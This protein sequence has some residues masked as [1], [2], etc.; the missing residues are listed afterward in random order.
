MEL[1]ANI[2]IALLTLAVLSRIG[3]DNPVY[4]GAQYLFVGVALGYSFVVLVQQVL[5]PETVLLLDNLSQPIA[6]LPLTVPF[7][8][9]LLLLPRAFGAAPASWLA[10][11]P[12]GLIFGV[13]AAVALVGSLAGTLFPQMLASLP[14]LAQ[15]PLQ[16]A[17]TAIVLIGVIAVLLRFTFTRPANQRSNRL[18]DGAARIGHWW[19]MIV[20]GVFFAGAL[21]T[22]LTALTERFEFLV[23]LTPFG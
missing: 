18:L 15:T 14:N 20:F 6:A 12:L 9:A 19:L 8:L 7:L 1:I 17:Q 10:N 23:G 2:I 21:V 13:G 5:L 3:G 11:I 22:Y 16:L 4:R